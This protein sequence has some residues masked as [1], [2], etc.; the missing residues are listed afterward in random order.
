MRAATITDIEKLILGGRPIATPDFTEVRAAARAM[1]ECMADL[2]EVQPHLRER[3]IA[4]Q[5]DR[6]V[7][8]TAEGLIEL[9]G[10]RD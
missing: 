1:A 6:M 7:A 5:V 2:G 8:E 9:Y 3:F 10:E 4:E